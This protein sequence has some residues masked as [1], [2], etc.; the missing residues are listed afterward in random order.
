MANK[1]KP[2]VPL[3]NGSGKG[4]RK[5]AGRGGHVPLK[6]GKGKSIPRK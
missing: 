5:N 3:K 2:G 4:T 6:N 1:G